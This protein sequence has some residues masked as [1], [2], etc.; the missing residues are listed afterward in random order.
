MK[1]WQLLP[2]FMESLKKVFYQNEHGIP[3]FQTVYGE[4]NGAFVAET[5]DK[6]EGDLP[7]RSQRL[8]KEYGE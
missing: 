2:Y 1:I 3:H 6:I 8:V 7:A 4:I 5:L